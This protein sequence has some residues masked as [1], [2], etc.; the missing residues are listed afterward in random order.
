MIF[1]MKYRVDRFSFFVL[2]VNVNEFHLLGGIDIDVQFVGIL[3][4]LQHSGAQALTCLVIPC[5]LKVLLVHFE[6]G[7]VYVSSVFFNPCL[8]RTSAILGGRGTFDAALRL[9]AF[10]L[11]CCTTSEMF[12]E[13]SF[14]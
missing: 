14:E 6:F 3:C 7:H 8:I 12:E 4:F 1:I 13:G 11:Y 10:C 5:A 9:S 2:H